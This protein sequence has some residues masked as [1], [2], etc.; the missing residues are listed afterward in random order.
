VQQLGANSRLERAGALL[1]QAQ[2]QMHVSEQASFVGG[3]E[4]GATRQLDRPAGIVEQGGREQEIRSQAG[5]ELRDLP[6]DRRHADRVLEQAA[7]IAVVA[8]G[9]R[10]QGP[11]LRTERLV[12]DEAPD[13]GSQAGVGDLG[14]QELEEP[15][16]LVGVPAHRGRQLGGVEAFGGLDGAHFQLEAVA[17]AVDPSE[18]AHG[19]ARGEAAVEQ[20]DVAPDAR[21]DTAARIDE[22]ER[23]IRGA[24]LGSQPLLLRDRVHALDDP[25]LLELRDRR[26]R[27]S[28]GPKTDE[29]GCVP[30]AP[31]RRGARLRRAGAAAGQ[32]RTR[33]YGWAA[34]AEIKPFRALRYDT[35]RAGPLEQLVAPPYDVIG[36]EERGRYLEQSPYNV[37][38]LTLPDSEEEAGRSFRSWREQGILTPEE[39]GFWALSQDYVGPDGVARTR[40]G[41]VASLRIEPYEAGT[42]LPHE[43]THRGPKEGRLR[44]LREVNAHPEPIFLLYEGDAPFD[45][46]EIA[47]ELETD[48]TRLWRLQDDTLAEA[49]ADRRLLIADG[50]HRY[51]TALAYHEELG[52]PESGYMMVVLVSSSDPGLM[53]FP[54]H[55]VVGSVNGPNPTHGDIGAALRDL[56]AGPRDRSAAVLYRRGGRISLLHGEEGQLDVELV[57]A[58]APKDVTYTAS[59]D[60]ALAAVER[61]RAEGAF[62]VRPLRVEDVFEVAA[63]GETMPQKSTYFYPKLVSGLLFQPL[64]R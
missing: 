32:G 3:L 6:A 43:R 25:V 63:R 2:A 55:R 56:E 8:F 52:T 37:V 30:A 50:H 7:G 15:F 28:L 4:D 58:Q 18:D 36:P 49:F 51:E 19:I 48:G 26:H 10:R 61:E 24:G 57:E 62:L 23:E 20:I 33:W 13:G 44:L 54:T 34:V 64:E 5:M 11:Q 53:I 40:T 38:H 29:V 59:I 12:V 45:V 21:L 17:E 31:G 27:S 35:E 1:D 47:P 42:V 39:P 22:L 60:D 16:E 41:L 46:P 9:R 14:G